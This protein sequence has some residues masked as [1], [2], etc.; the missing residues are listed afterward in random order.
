LKAQAQKALDAGEL[1]KADELLA[2]VETE[3]RQA[4][5]RA[6]LNAAETSA[7]RG[8]LA[9]TRLRYREAAKHFANAAALFV[10]GGPQEK[11]RV[12]YLEK[13]AGALLRQGGDFGEKDTLHASIERHRALIALKPR[14]RVPLKWA[15][16]QYHLGLALA[17]LGFNERGTAWFEEAL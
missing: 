14:D 4:V 10:P 15:A 13:E 11:K 7:R 5:E 9:M 2:A 8:D 1:D 6:I 17:R 16:A 3:Q 12:R